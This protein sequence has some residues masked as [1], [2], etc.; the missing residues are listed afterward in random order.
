MSLFGEGVS[1]I[2]A[3]EIINSV[4]TKQI[5]GNWGCFLISEQQ[6]TGTDFPTHPDIELHG[7]VKVIVTRPPSTYT[8]LLQYQRRTARLNNKGAVFYIMCK[9]DMDYTMSND[10]Y[11]YYL[12][13]YLKKE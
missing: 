8:E 6:G 11:L 3:N 10:V 12:T 9:Q 4:F 2:R 5:N 7:G 13:N 1:A